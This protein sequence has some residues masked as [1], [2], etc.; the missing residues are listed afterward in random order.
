MAAETLT[1][2]DVVNPAGEVLGT[3]KAL[4]LDVPSGRIAYTVLSFGGL[5]GIGDKLFA[6][7]WPALTL[8]TD[9]KRFILDLDKERL[10]QAPG[11]DKE[12][13]PAMADPQW[14]AS[15]HS[16]YNVQPYWDYT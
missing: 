11:F 10:I 4:M 3:I 15:I 1:G 5:L 16:Y 7:P 2:D 6:I 13:W 12:H 8:D 14:A 9:H